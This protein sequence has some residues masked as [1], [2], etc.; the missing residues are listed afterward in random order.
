MRRGLQL[1]SAL[2]LCLGLGALGACATADSLSAFETTRDAGGPSDATTPSSLPFSR[3]NSLCSGVRG[4]VCEPDNGSGCLSDAASVGCVVSPQGLQCTAV[5]AGAAGADCKA[6]SDCGAGLACARLSSDE[7]RC[8]AYCCVSGC[9]A[10]GEY[11]ALGTEA[12]SLRRLPL[13]K[14]ADS[15]SIGGADCSV[16]TS[17]TPVGIGLT[18]CVT[19]GPMLAG[20]S[21]AME[22]CAQ[23]LA[24]VGLGGER[25]CLRLCSVSAPACGL[26]EVCVHPSLTVASPDVGYCID[27]NAERSR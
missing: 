15:C 13:C 12:A 26:G 2:G 10:A 7:A 5:G 22:N 18:A 3:V 4:D 23:G 8:A 24:C 14:R 27:P 21:C 16:G 9:S 11:C 6:T 20:Q 25:T 17:C 1:Y 19:T